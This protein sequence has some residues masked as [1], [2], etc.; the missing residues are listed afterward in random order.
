MFTPMHAIIAIP[1]IVIFPLLVGLFATYMGGF[2][3]NEHNRDMR[4]LDRAVARRDYKANWHRKF[5][6]RFVTLTFELGEKRWLCWVERR[7]VKNPAYLHNGKT[8]DQRR[9]Y[10]V[11]YRDAQQNDVVVKA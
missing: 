7:F 1:Y 10:N 8:R 5:A 2:R 6:W 11:E 3:W 4:R 9:F